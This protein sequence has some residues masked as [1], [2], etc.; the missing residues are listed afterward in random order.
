MTVSEIP[1]DTVVLFETDFAGENPEKI[2]KARDR[3]SGRYLDSGRLLRE[4]AWNQVGGLEIVTCSHHAGL[5]CNILFADGR[6][7]FVRKKD[8][9]N[10]RWEP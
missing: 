1:P 4:G 7:E 6:V 2:I 9:P 3:A 8:L 10:L 5:G